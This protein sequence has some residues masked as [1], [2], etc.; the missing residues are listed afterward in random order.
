MV[1][2]PLSPEQLEEYRRDGVILLPSLLDKSTLTRLHETIDSLIADAFD[3]DDTSILELEPEAVDGEAVVRRIHDPCERH[4][5][6]R[7]LCEDPR[8]LDAIES[9]IGPDIGLHHSKLNMKPSRVGS[10]VEWHQD[11]AYFPHTNDD[12]VT[13]LVY[14]DDA[15]LENGCL[16]VA[17]GLHHSYLDHHDEAD[18]FS[19]LITDEAFTGQ[20]IPARP[21]PAPAGSVILMHC[22]LPHSSLPNRSSESRRTLIYEYRACDSLPILYSSRAENTEKKARL[23]RGKPARFA[24]LAGPPPRLPQLEG[25]KSLYQLQEETLARKE[26]EPPPGA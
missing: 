22:L 17:P 6:F 24:R 12:L 26:S 10:A 7:E 4:Q 25:D 2:S 1:N 16:Q 18:R 9:L 8:I 11:L 15:S 23:L 3:R 13:A 5:V 20:A 21:L 19:G 14:L